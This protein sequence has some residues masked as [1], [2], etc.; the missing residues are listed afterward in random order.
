[1]RVSILSGSIIA[2]IFA[3]APAALAQDLIDESVP[4]EWIQDYLPEKLPELKYPQY[5]NDLDKA[6]EQV[7]RGRCKTALM[8]LQKIYKGDAAQIA[9]VKASAMSALGRRAEAVAVLSDKAIAENAKV[10][11]LRA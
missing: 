6:R 11:V 1:M 8:T 3:L 5:Y 7:Y 9:M 2:A 4:N 10:R